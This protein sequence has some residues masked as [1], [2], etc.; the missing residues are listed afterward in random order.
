[1][2]AQEAL[3]RLEYTVKVMRQTWQKLAIV[4]GLDDAVKICVVIHHMAEGFQRKFSEAAPLQLFIEALRD[5]KFNPQLSHLAGLSCKAC[6]LSSLPS[7]KSKMYSLAKLLRHFKVNHGEN[8][9]Q[10]VE[11]RLDWRVDMIWLP[12]M[13]A[14]MTLRAVI[15]KDKEALQAVSDALPWAF[16]TPYHKYNAKTDDR[17]LDFTADHDPATAWQQPPRAVREDFGRRYEHAAAPSLELDGF[18]FVDEPSM[19]SSWKQV[20]HC[21]SSN[22]EQKRS[23]IP[24]AGLPTDGLYSAPW[25]SSWT[26]DH[27]SN[28]GH[29]P[30]H[31]Y[32]PVH[33]SYERHPVESYQRVEVRDPRG[34]PRGDN[35]PQRSLR[36]S[37]PGDV[38]YRNHG[39]PYAVSCGT[40]Y[41]NRS[42]DSHVHVHGAA[43]ASSYEEYDPRFPA[44]GGAGFSHRERRVHA[45]L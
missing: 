22:Y 32:Y 29:D 34:D 19:L 28:H 1:M 23:K 37:P 36:R 18:E 40:H 20:G 38:Y 15:G 27:Q 16:E 30:R 33:P 43:S 24:Q 14:L 3:V 4:K 2:R 31:A 42:V 26:H 10:R 5:P 13:S 12:P 35:L 21:T 8:A 6:Q 41:H 17:T 9:A 11:K 39:Q 25:S 7:P 45:A 44:A